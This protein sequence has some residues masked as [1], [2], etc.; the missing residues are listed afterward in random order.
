MATRAEVVAAARAE[1]DTPWV[2]QG[3]TPGLQLDCAGH[4]IVVARQLELVAADFDV[5]GYSMWPDGTMLEWCDRFMVRIPEI[6][7]GAVVVTATRDEP[8][9]LGFAGDYVHGGFSLIHACNAAHPPRVIETRLLFTRTLKLRA[10]YRLPG[11]A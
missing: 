8:G 5:N 2:H 6:E 11:V 1:L 4:I 10:V 3:R 9:H 7:L